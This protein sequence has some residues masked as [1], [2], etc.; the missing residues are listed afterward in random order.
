MPIW[1][2]WHAKG[3]TMRLFVRD[4]YWMT[5]WWITTECV[6]ISIGYSVGNNYLLYSMEWLLTMESGMTIDHG[7]TIE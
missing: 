6:C 4:N 7:M 2:K 1:L 3:M 5:M